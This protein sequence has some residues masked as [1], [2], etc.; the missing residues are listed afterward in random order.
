MSTTALVDEIHTAWEE[1]QHTR[2]PASHEPEDPTPPRRNAAAEAR[3][4]RARRTMEAERA[5]MFG[6]GSEVKTVGESSWIC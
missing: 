1:V 4:G 5:Y 3:R 6:F 2:P